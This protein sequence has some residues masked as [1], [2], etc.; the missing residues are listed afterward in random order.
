MSSAPVEGPS[1]ADVRASV[2]R[3]R[4]L[5]GVAL[6]PRSRRWIINSGEVIFELL[7]QQRLAKWPVA[8]RMMESTSNV[9]LR[10]IHSVNPLLH[11]GERHRSLRACFQAL[12][13]LPDHEARVRRAATETI[14]RFV[15]EA[16]GDELDVVALGDRVAVAVLTELVGTKMHVM[17]ELALLSHPIAAAMEPQ[18][19]DVMPADAVE[20]AAEASLAVAQDACDAGSVAVAGSTLLGWLRA[21]SDA[22]DFEAHELPAILVVLA[23]TGHE[24][25]AAMVGSVVAQLATAPHL[26][27]EI[28]CDASNTREIVRELARLEAPVQYFEYGAADDGTLKNRRMKRGDIVTLG[29]GAACRDSTLLDDA[30]TV[31]PHRS[32]SNE[33]LFGAGRHRCPGAKLAMLTGAAVADEL[34]HGFDFT[35]SGPDIWRPQF[36]IRALEQASVRLVE[37]RTEHSKGT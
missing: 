28:R 1:A 30:D 17:A 14:R 16:P 13:S 12:Y 11:D 34:C 23:M 20:R 32:R 26:Q 29:F 8:D 21:R 31:C 5:R 4:A 18:Q 25:T 9:E 27:E 7:R 36:T 6:I 10:L 33:L 37:R 19:L 15:Q 22:G 3:L 35:S 24:T 2:E